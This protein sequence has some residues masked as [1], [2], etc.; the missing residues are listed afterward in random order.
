MKQIPCVSRA[1]NL[2]LCAGSVFD[3][4]RELANC[5]GNRPLCLPP[6]RLAIEILQEFRHRL[7]PGHQ[8]LIAPPGA[9]DV[10]QVAF[11]VVDLLQI[12][13]VITAFCSPP[14]RRAR[15]SMKVSEVRNSM[16]YFPGAVTHVSQNG[17][18]Q[19]RIEFPENKEN[20]REFLKKPPRYRYVRDRD[21]YY[22]R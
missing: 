18:E 21:F 2:A 7:H 4:D 20:N 22:S 9:G 13:V 12:D 6:F 11:G 3:G 15:L 5:A 10:E 19:T 8:Q 16:S 14:G 1:G 17:G